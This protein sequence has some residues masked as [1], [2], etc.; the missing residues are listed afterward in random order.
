MIIRIKANLSSLSLAIAPLSPTFVLKFFPHVEKN[1]TVSLERGGGEFKK[2]WKTFF[3][4]K[5]FVSLL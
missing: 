1:T 3:L 4:H 2:N 5:M